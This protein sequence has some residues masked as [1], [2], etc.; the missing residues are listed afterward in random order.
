MKNKFKAFA[1]HLGISLVIFIAILY[2]IIFHWYPPPFFTTDGGWQGIKIIAAVDLV[3]GPVLTFIVYKKGKA[4]LKFDLSVI[5][6]IQTSALAWGLWVVHH[7][8]PYAA[9]FSEDYMIT[10]LAN[11]IEN[12]FDDNRLQKFGGRTPL[13][14]YSD[15][16]EDPEKM[17]KL[18]IESINIQRNLHM[19][20]EYYRVFDDYAKEKMRRKGADIASWV[21]DKPEDKKRLNEFL[22]E[23]AEL[24]GKM[25]FYP[26]RARHEW[27]FIVLHKESFEYIGLLNILPPVDGSVIKPIEQ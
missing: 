26:W 23:H 21:E 17:Q 7:E 15:Y 3:L 6:L 18:R 14:I 10:L 19:F 8:R 20:D 12:R 16:P 22:D 1:A 27:Y 9:V 11:D 25:L 4:S 13:W 5:A 2:V 24:E